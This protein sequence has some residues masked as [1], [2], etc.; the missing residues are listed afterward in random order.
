MDKIIGKILDA[1]AEVTDVPREHIL[2]KAR[3]EEV[4]VA[5]KL[6]IN[7]CLKYGYSTMSIAE[8]THRTREG[9]RKMFVSSL[10]DED[11]RK[12]YR[13]YALLINEKLG[14]IQRE[15]QEICT[16]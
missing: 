6:F 13:I 14:K 15:T 11:T 5:R 4:I 1:V 10:R 7:F 3:T 16:I 8:V 9:I 12:I 2:G